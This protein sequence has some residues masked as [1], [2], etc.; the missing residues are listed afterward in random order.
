MLDCIV[1]ATRKGVYARRHDGR[2]LR[3]HL[4]SFAIMCSSQ[5]TINHRICPRNLPPSLGV[6]VTFADASIQLGLRL[7]SQ[8]HVWAASW[9]RTPAPPEMDHI[10]EAVEDSR[11]VSGAAWLGG[12]VRDKL[13]GECVEERHRREGGVWP[14]AEEGGK[15]AWREPGDGSSQLGFTP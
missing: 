14:R 2:T 7:P 3:P 1:A 10:V 13:V 5:P 4:D 12:V 9:R 8:G 6:S 11:F 15:G